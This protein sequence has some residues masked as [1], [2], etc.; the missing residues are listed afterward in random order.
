MTS[1]NNIHT[2]NG[3]PIKRTHIMQSLLVLHAISIV[4]IAIT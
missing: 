1:I 2:F 3:S 4:L